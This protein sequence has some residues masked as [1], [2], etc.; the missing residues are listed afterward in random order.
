MS[1]QNEGIK[2]FTA[3]EAL[4]AYRRVKLSSGSGTQ[5][6]YADAGDEFI[7]ITQEKVDSGDPVAVRLRS[8]GKSFLA[9]AAEAFAV[10]ATL[11]GGDDGKV[12]DTASG[13][14][15]GTALE[16]ATAAGDIV[17]ILLDNGAD[18]DIDG[19]SVAVEAEGGNGAVPVLFRKSGITDASTAAAIVASLP[20]AVKIVEWWVISR[21]T[22]AAN[23]KLQD[24]TPTD[25][26]ANI[27]KGTADD[28]IVRGGTIVAEA[29]ELAAGAALK[30]L[31]S[32]AAAFDVFVLC[33]KI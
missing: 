24:G 22:T 19:A 13:N 1:T 17:E 8:A 27:A 5:V 26:T 21:D 6:E 20:F 28:T 32:T 3:G 10:G 29:D 18:S 31:A 7:G 15:Q 30:V 4:E 9:V 16:A 14:A 33:V 12:Q 25:L 23:V 2:T 11:Y